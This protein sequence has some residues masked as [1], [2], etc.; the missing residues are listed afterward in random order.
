M[1]DHIVY[2]DEVCSHEGCGQQAVEQD[3]YEMD[4]CADHEK[5][6]MEWDRADEGWKRR[7]E[8]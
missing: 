4:L 3:Y 1:I 6:E 2:L 8:E 7:Q 5:Y